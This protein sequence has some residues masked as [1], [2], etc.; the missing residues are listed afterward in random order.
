MG[1]AVTRDGE[2][3]TLGVVD[4]ELLR[5]HWSN[6]RTNSPAL[7]PPVGDTESKAVHWLIREKSD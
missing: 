7:G 5:S 4:R 2:G 6:N 1:L 3:L